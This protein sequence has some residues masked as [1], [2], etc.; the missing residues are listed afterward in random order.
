MAGELNVGTLKGY[1]TLDTKGWDR[2]VA[3]LRR[4]QG[5]LL[6]N[7]GTL[8]SAALGAGV[9]ITG[10]L[11]MVV[12]EFGKFEKAM[13]I[14]TSVSEVTEA[15]FVKMSRAAEDVA[16]KWAI[17]AE[18]AAEAYLLLGRAGLTAEQQ[19][20]AFVPVLTASKAM[21]TDLET[22]AEGV[23]N[24]MN[25]FQMS[26]DKTGSAVDIITFAVNK[27]TQSLED[28][29]IAMS[30]AAK[31]A[32]VMNNTLEDTA[33]MLALV[34]NQGIRGSKA[35]TALRF[36]LTSLADPV[37]EAKVLLRD[38]GV[39]VYD[40][41]GRTQ[42]FIET[43]RELEEATKGASEE[44]KNYVYSTL[45]GK[46]ALPSM[47]ALFQL[48]SARVQ[49]FSNTLRD[50]AGEAERTGAKQM[51]AL[52]AQVER[53]YQMFL[54]LTRHIGMAFAPTVQRA[55]DVMQKWTTKWKEMIDANQEGV[56]RFLENLTKMAATFLKFGAM[57][58][59]IP[60]I[61]QLFSGLTTIVFSPFGLIIG[62]IVA[63]QVIFNKT[64]DELKTGVQTWWTDIKS[65]L[66]LDKLKEYGLPKTGGQWLVGT[67]PLAAG[68]LYLMNKW[69]GKNKERWAKLK[70]NYTP[71]QLSTTL[72]LGKPEEGEGLG[73]RTMRMVK[74][75]MEFAMKGVMDVMQK[76]MPGD[77]QPIFAQL[78]AA[79]DDLLKSWNDQTPAIEAATEATNSYLDTA[80]KIANNGSLQN[81]I[82]QSNWSLLAAKFKEDWRNAIRGV[83][84]NMYSWIESYQ[85][86]LTDMRTG[87]E[88]A[89][90][91]LMQKG[92]SFKTFMS[93]IF[94]AIYQS[95]VQMVAQMIANDMFSALLGN[96]SNMPMNPS[97]TSGI[98]SIIR[99]LITGV[100]GGM[101]MENP[102]A[103]GEYD[104]GGGYGAP[105]IS[106][107]VHNNSGF[108]IAAK[109]VAVAQNG[110]DFVMRM[111]VEG[112]QSSE[113]FRRIVK[114]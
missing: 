55:V 39:N 70:E 83:R 51:K 76:Y 75:N 95:F 65:I 45:F 96:R 69:M 92:S 43:M 46:R 111:V 9:A 72:P 41:T 31:P 105:K 22:T 32:Q 87:W 78:Q 15:Q 79:F 17:P 1:I 11:T 110:R 4:S 66:E 28:M 68:S 5:N 113:D 2:G 81:I 18:K 90:V 80:N 16:I 77:L 74:S 102:Y 36:A 89:F 59:I 50:A 88:E 73:D 24:M 37:G 3:S 7:M 23:V 27:S 112:I 40:M 53:L 54:M 20:Q 49:E 29:L 61:V 26:F 101:P 71:S 48:G 98:L 67:N 44:F 97:A 57:L 64:L 103:G 30:Y 94:D 60:K 109:T 82:R 8:G 84:E 62:G 107:N 52:L 19:M 14:A 12:R 108:P 106:I 13:R 38:L 104:V 99:G 34:A 93:D 21:M 100:G 47:M 63:V 35:G 85:K 42:P 91:G 25:A 56:K 58:I 10:M 33:A 114:A 6:A 86:M